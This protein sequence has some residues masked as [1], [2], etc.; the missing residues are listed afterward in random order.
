MEPI[1]RN[2]TPDHPALQWNIYPGHPIIMVAHAR[3]PR[4]WAVTCQH[5]GPLGLRGS[6]ADVHALIRS[7]G[8]GLPSSTLTQ[9]LRG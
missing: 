2:T 9:P 8:D 5:C 3:H 4:L 7:H 6:L 1:A